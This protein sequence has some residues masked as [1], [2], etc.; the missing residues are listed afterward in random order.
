MSQNPCLKTRGKRLRQGAIVSPLLKRRW[1]IV[2]GLAALFLT[3]LPSIFH[4]R[5][6]QAGASE[7][8][9]RLAANEPPQGSTANP[10][11]TDATE[12]FVV[13]EGKAVAGAKVWLRRQAETT[14]GLTWEGPLVSDQ[15]GRVEFGVERGMAFDAV[16]IDEKGRLGKTYLRRTIESKPEPK[17]ILEPTTTIEGAIVH[18]GKPVSGVQCKSIGVLSK[19]SAP[20]GYDFPDRFWPGEVRSDEQGRIRVPLVPMGYG[21][22]CEFTDERFAWNRTL[23]SSETANTISLEKAGRLELEFEGAANPVKPAQYSWDLTVSQMEKNKFGGNEGYMSSFF[24]G[25]NPNSMKGNVIS[26]IKP[27]KYKLDIKNTAISTC[28]FHLEQD[29]E[30]KADQVTKIKIPTKEGVQITG[31]I[32]DATTGKGVP[33]Y[34][35]SLYS[36]HRV[37]DDRTALSREARTDLQEWANG[38]TD[39]EGNYEVYVRGKARYGFV[40]HSSHNMSTDLDRYRLT[41]FDRE[42]LTYGVQAEVPESGKFTFPD[43]LLPPSQKVRGLV[44]NNHGRSLTGAIE[45]FDPS[46]PWKTHDHRRE[47]ELKE[48]SFEWIGIPPE[49]LMT[50]RIRQGK[51]VNIPVELSPAQWKDG[52]K[53]ALD[54]GNAVTFVGQVQDEEGHPVPKTRLYLSWYFLIPEEGGPVNGHQLMETVETDEQ[55]RF[56][57]KGHWPKERYYLHVE[58]PQYVWPG[59]SS[60]LLNNEKTFSDRDEYKLVVDVSMG[61]KFHMNDMK[62]GHPGETVDYGIIR[63]VKS[64]KMVRGKTIGLDGLPIP[65]IQV[66]AVA[67]GQGSL[68]TSTDAQ[69]QFHVGQLRGGSGFLIAKGAGYRATYVPF[70]SGSNE[71]VIQIRRNSEP[72]A[73]GPTISKEYLAARDKMVRHVLESIWKTRQTS[74]WGARM[75]ES[76]VALDPARARLW[77]EQA[78]PQEKSN[79][80]EIQKPMTYEEAVRLALINIDDGIAAAKKIRPDRAIHLVLV[81]ER[82]LKTHPEL[83]LRFAEEAVVQFRAM[84]PT[85][86]F[87]KAPGLVEA[88]ALVW[89]AGKK[90]SGRQLIQEGIDVLQK[91]PQNQSFQDSNAAIAAFLAPIDWPLAVKHLDLSADAYKYN[92][93]L[94]GCIQ[95]IAKDNP[96]GARGKTALFKEEKD[97]IS[98]FPVKCRLDLAKRIAETDLEGALKV[99]EEIKKA[100]AFTHSYA[101]GLTELAVQIHPKDP[102]RAYRLIDQAFDFLDQFDQSEERK[103]WGPICSLLGAQMVYLARQIDYPDPHALVARTLGYLGKPPVEEYPSEKE[104]WRQTVI[105]LAL[106]DPVLAKKVLQ[107]HTSVD[108]IA[109]EWSGGEEPSQRSRNRREAGFILALIAP[110]KA[111]AVF[112]SMAAKGWT[113]EMVSSAAISEIF[114]SF[115]KKGDL[116]KNINHWE[117]MMWMR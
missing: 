83:S 19:G 16:A 14:W 89:K 41:R 37:H 34:R 68:N 66:I 76:M 105:A 57:L 69:G 48:G 94:L 12:V 56:K 75:L 31:R 82:L 106:T 47:R 65:G 50:L 102:A 104:N 73:A 77:L 10:S 36:S 58:N 27:G 8:E 110:E 61:K 109:K 51:A 111:I 92:Y 70:Q 84:G 49:K 2:L 39:Q 3:G 114:S 11:G 54:E 38:M 71:L 101:Q 72:P 87:W 43:L 113:S 108:E 40:Y 97:V 115:A 9:V 81:G 4:T 99:L 17:I 25:D 1:V 98:S 116:M 22:R 95:Q 42:T 91:D 74:G 96:A 112:D 26:R 18:L 29:L 44:S 46:W 63:L 33:N 59:F 64:T 62:M 20:Q 24:H 93:A 7:S 107:M 30:I 85:R 100:Q 5:A 52:L 86:Y 45:V 103:G 23:L 88:G 80:S 55:G 32:V 15:A 78:T 6:A 117:L 21:V 53:I 67:D 13:A 28:L 79:W 60:P 35:F 90:E